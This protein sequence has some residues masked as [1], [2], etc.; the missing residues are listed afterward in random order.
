M[1]RQ[2]RIVIPSIPHHV[3]QRGNFQQPVFRRDDDYRTYCRLMNEYSKKHTMPV[4]AFCL[5]GNHVH[6]ITV[7]STDSAL[8]RVFHAVHTRYAQYANENRQRK[9]H[10]WQG[11][12]YSCPM[13]DTHLCRAIRYVERNP[14]R[15]G[16]VAYPWEYKWSSAATHVGNA[17]SPIEIT[18]MDSFNDTS[19]WKAYL[20]YP[21]TPLE[22]EIRRGTH[23]G[24]PVGTTAFI[25]KLERE[26]G[27]VLTP[28][29]PGR[30]KKE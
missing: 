12:F 4:L 15:A 7:P 9:G 30:P 25:E 22:E 8:A 13:D 29:R 27:R 3:T 28:Q 6:F 10:L 18:D 26:L 21:D 19:G 2:P 23:K 11:R 16:I 24:L 17:R 1:P 20:Q 5:M 14:V